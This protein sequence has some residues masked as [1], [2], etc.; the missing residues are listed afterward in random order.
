MHAS[1][2]DKERLTSHLQIQVAN[3]QVSSRPNFNPLPCHHPVIQFVL[4][5]GEYPGAELSCDQTKSLR[6]TWVKMAAKE[7]KMMRLFEDL[8]YKYDDGVFWLT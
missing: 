4:K 8:R 7:G 1:T 3:H 6:K 5:N 2:G